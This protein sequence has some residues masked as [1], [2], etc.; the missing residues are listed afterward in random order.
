MSGPTF[1]IVIAAYEATATIDRAVSSALEQT[2]PAR[3]VIVV[4]DGSRDDLAGALRPFSEQ[5]TLIRQENRGAGAARNAAA[6][7][8]SSEFI[9]VLDADDA[10]HPHRLE[11]LGELSRRRPHLDLITTDARLIV[12]G[13]PTGTFADYTPFVAEG[14]RTAIFGSCF[15]GGWPAIRLSRFRAIGGFDETLKIAQDWDCWLRAILDGAEAG[16]VE[17]PYYDYHVHADS[18]S[19]S[20][21]ASLWERARMLEKAERSPALRAAERPAL[22]R[23]LRMHRSR[24]LMAEVQDSLYGERARGGL[25][26]QAFSR[27]LEP[28]TRLTALAA[29]LAPPLARRLVPPYRPAEERLSQEVG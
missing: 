5:V 24:A 3:E 12:D 14:Q 18:L 16:F 22:E 29:T 15:V 4:D 10:Y 28:G 17:E 19:S 11:A 21:A 1:S 25:A 26:R 13:R 6:A 27:R 23:A 8:A 7:A 20:R 2:A 9:A